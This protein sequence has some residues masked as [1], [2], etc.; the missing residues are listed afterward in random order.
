MKNFDEQ[1]KIENPPNGGNSQAPYGGDTNSI[2][3]QS[4]LS[5]KKLAPSVTNSD[6]TIFGLEFVR[7][8][9]SNYL[10][11]LEEL[12][13][14]DEKFNQ[15]YIDNQYAT[16]LTRK[17]NSEIDFK[18][19]VIEEINS[20]EEYFY[21]IAIDTRHQ[22]I[23]NPSDKVIGY[24]L[25]FL[26]DKS[27]FYIEEKVG[28]IDGIYVDEECRGLGLGKLLISHAEDFCKNKNVHTISLSSKIKNTK[29]IKLYRELG[30]VEQDVMMFKKII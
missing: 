22:A 26:K 29:A 18:K 11:Y 7:V 17:V 27:N 1:S 10:K 5:N 6:S 16:A 12:V 28:F 14:L 20:D 4:S 25:C 21:E 13:K 2:S 23:D 30:F 19:N 8:D 9:K 3:D 24:V 15:I